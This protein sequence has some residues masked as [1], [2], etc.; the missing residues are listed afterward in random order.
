[1]AR[2]GQ[3]GGRA[4]EN[5]VGVGVEDRYADREPAILQVDGEDD[6]GT[7]PARVPRYTSS[8]AS[9]DRDRPLREVPQVTHRSQ[10]SR[11][12]APQLV[13]GTTRSRSAQS[14][15]SLTWLPTDR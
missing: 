1:L 13:T 2:Y 5:L 8:K 12:V 15:R 4:A 6:V 11:A 7:L 10:N 9:T 14:F 3:T